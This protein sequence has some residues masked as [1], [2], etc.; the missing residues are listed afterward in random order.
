MFVIQLCLSDALCST[1]VLFYIISYHLQ[2][3]SANNIITF[4]LSYYFVEYSFNK[5]KKINIKVENI[6]ESVTWI[7]NLSK[8][9]SHSLNIKVCLM[10]GIRVL[11]VLG[12]WS[13]FYCNLDED[14][15]QKI[16]SRYYLFFKQNIFELTS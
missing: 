16:L 1:C 6:H 14:T 4:P 10:K 8:I 2:T 3:F 12:G 7:F 13:H 5:S 11:R 15:V 9:Y